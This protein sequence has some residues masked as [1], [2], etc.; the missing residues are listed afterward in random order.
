M[1]QCISDA[2]GIRLR[3]FFRLRLLSLDREQVVEYLN[4]LDS[5]TKALKSELLKLCWFMRGGLSYNDAMLLSQ[6]EKDM[7]IKLINDNLDT[8]KESGMPFF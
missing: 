4:T 2:F 3:Q 6:T 5:E 8:T 7:I 1:Q